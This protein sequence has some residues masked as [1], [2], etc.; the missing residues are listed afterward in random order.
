MP[1]INK[2][3]LQWSIRGTYDRTRTLITDLSI[4]EYATAAGNNLQGALS[5]FLVSARRDIQDGHAV[6]QMGNIWGRMFY[7][8]C[9]ALP[10]SVQASCGAGKDYQ[11]DNK[12]FVVWVGAGNTTKD[13]ITKNLW[14]SK[15]SAANSPWNYGL[16]WG[17]PIVDRPLRGEKNEGVGKLHILGNTLPEY[18]TSWSSTMTYKRLSVYALVDA[19]IGFQINNQGEGWGLFDMNSANFDQANASVEVAKPVGYTWRAGGAEGVGSGGL[20]DQLGP[21]NYN[22]ENGSYAKV[23]EMN[24]SYHIGGL[25][26]IGDWTVALVGRNLFTFTKYTGY[27]PETGSSGGQ[28]GSGLI[29]QID[30]F[31]FPTLRTFTF[32]VTTRF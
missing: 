24:A 5:F 21:N 27:D 16:Q 6:N 28:T 7:R 2:R 25:R 17:H 18:R 20:Y 32:S 14:Q 22:V 12:G 11:V 9:G 15:L 29:S 10:A 13:G 1:L 8:S 31:G 30:A 19:T 4:P 26:G 23:R 3:N